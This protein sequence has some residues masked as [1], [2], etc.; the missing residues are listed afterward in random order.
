MSKFSEAPTC[1]SCGRTAGLERNKLGGR[2]YACCRCGFTWNGRDGQLNT[3]RRFVSQRSEACIYVQR[4]LKCSP[5]EASEYVDTLGLKYI[6]E[7][8]Q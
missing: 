1:H 7:N 6:Q 5:L 8:A 3:K 4:I 2:Y